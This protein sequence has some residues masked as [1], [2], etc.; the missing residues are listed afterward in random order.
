MQVQGEVKCKT[1]NTV[2]DWY[3]KEIFVKGDACERK[4]DG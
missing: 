3:K 1:I 2:K 4:N